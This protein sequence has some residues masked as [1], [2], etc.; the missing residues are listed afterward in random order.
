[1]Q[2][3]EDPVVLATRALGWGTLYSIMGTGTIAMAFVGIW[4][5]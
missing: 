4:K 1:M 5:V 3:H 2:E